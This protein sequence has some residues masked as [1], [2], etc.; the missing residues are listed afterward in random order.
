M[1][2]SFLVPRQW[3]STLLSGRRDARSADHTAVAFV[4]SLCHT[5]LMLDSLDR[6]FNARDI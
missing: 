4:T 6:W 2:R 1:V 3:H 5:R